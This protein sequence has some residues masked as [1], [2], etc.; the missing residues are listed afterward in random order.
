MNSTKI[1]VSTN[2]SAASSARLCAAIVFAPHR[3]RE[4]S[5]LPRD[6]S[7]SAASRARLCAATVFA[8]HRRRERSELPRDI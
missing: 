8:P 3:R 5:E 7:T 1:S 6:I 4:R 2:T